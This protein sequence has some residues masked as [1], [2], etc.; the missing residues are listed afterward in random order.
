MTIDEITKAIDEDEPCAD[1][2][3]SALKTLRTKMSINNP[4]ARIFH[5]AVDYDRLM[6]E[7]GFQSFRNENPK[8][9]TSLL[10][11]KLY[12]LALRTKIKDDFE[13]MPKLK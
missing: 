9:A 4:R 5:L 11:D 6:E 8:M 2:V 12:P 10:A 13:F 7:S 1:A 3:H